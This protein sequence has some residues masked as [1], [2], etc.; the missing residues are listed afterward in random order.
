MN[1]VLQDTAAICVVLIAAEAVERLC[2]EDAM[3][4][5]VRGMAVLALLSS[6]VASALSCD[7]PLSLPDSSVEN[8]KSELSGYLEEQTE[9]AVQEETERYLQGLFAAAGLVAEKIEAFTDIREGSGIVLTKVSVAFAYET[10]TE[11]AR[12]LLRSTLGDEIELEVQT[13][14]R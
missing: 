14:G 4:H 5:F 8:T 11:R 12:A 10:D 3:V 13:N 2:S 7:W 9:W 6:L 1:T